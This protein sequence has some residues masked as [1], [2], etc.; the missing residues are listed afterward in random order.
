MCNAVIYNYQSTSKT[1]F[2]CKPKPAQL[3][4]I[5][6]HKTEGNTTP[7]DGRCVLDWFSFT[8]H[9]EDTR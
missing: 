7:K 5:S 3:A 1:A 9:M 4:T 6:S 8:L 2:P